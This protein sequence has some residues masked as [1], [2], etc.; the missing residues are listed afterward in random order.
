MK[1]DYALIV[2]IGQHLSCNMEYH[3]AKYGEHVS[4]WNEV[5]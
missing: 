4:T 5:M 3:R 1:I 2:M